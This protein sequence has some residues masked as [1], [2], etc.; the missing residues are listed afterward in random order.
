[1]V[2]AAESESGGA[3]FD[4]RR[5]RVTVWVDFW[6]CR[7]DFFMALGM[8][9]EW[10]GD[11]LG[12]GWDGVGRWRGGRKISEIV[13]FK[14]VWEYLFG[15]GGIKIRGFGILLDQ[16]IDSRTKIDLFC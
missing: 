8:C 11:V 7:G 14:N 2:G 4:S 10:S 12:W 13:F 16:Q 3:G 1:M 6:S 15:V 9:G 5:A